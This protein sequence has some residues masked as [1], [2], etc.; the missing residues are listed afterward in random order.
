MRRAH[1]R[2]HN[3]FKPQLIHVAGFNLS[4]IF[5][6][7]LGAGTPREWNNLGRMQFLFLLGL[8]TLQPQFYRRC[9]SMVF[10]SRPAWR[11]EWSNICSE[12]I[13]QRGSL[14]FRKMPRPPSVRRTMAILT[15]ENPSWVRSK[16]VHPAIP[17]P[18]LQSNRV[19]LSIAKTYEQIER[20]F[21]DQVWHVHKM[22][23]LLAC[24]R[25]PPR[26]SKDSRPVAR[27]RMWPSIDGSKMRGAPE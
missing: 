23:R 7:L 4:L 2:K 27:P 14:E 15:R 5:R 11:V 13:W 12:C 24:R 3:I 10:R 25:I 9:R 21:R 22:P 1:L 26:G 18:N 8:F 6:K 17:I 19:R 20:S 16:T